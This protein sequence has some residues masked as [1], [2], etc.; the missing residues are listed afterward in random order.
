[1]NPIGLYLIQLAIAMLT[2]AVVGAAV[3]L[4]ALVAGRPLPSSTEDMT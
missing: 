3:S 4:I 1:M 2:L